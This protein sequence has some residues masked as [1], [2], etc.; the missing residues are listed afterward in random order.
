MLDVL[1]SI[2]YTNEENEYIDRFDKNK[3]HR[4]RFKNT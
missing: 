2:G 1:I 4:N 3:L